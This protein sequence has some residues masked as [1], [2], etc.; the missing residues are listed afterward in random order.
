MTKFFLD[1]NQ[2]KKFNNQF[3]NSFNGII[4]STELKQTSSC[5]FGQLTL[6]YGLIK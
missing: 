3:L 2:Q 5:A 4:E 1:I 6:K